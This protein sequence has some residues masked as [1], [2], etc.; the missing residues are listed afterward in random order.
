MMTATRTMVADIVEKLIVEVETALSLSG[1]VE[2]GAKGGGVQQN[3]PHVRVIPEDEHDID[4]YAIGNA[5][6]F[7]LK[8]VVV[9][10]TVDVSQSPSEGEL[11][12]LYRALDIYDQI[13]GTSTR[14]VSEYAVETR[15]TGI[16][17]NYEVESVAGQHAACRIECDMIKRH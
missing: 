4:S 12:N 16:I 7:T 17:P 14:D 2:Y 9:A 10:V 5:D 13:V 11:E 8:F 1:D 6:M 3:L 15:A